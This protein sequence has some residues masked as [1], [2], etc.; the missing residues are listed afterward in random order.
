MFRCLACCL[1]LP[2]SGLALLPSRPLPPV[3]APRDEPVPTSADRDEELR[4]YRV[5]GYGNGQPNGEPSLL[6]VGD[7]GLAGPIRTAYVADFRGIFESR[8]NKATLP[9]PSQLE[10]ADEVLRSLE[11]HLR[12]AGTA[13]TDRRL[14]AI[15]Y[16]LRHLP[17]MDDYSA[18]PLRWKETPL[19]NAFVTRTQGPFHRTELRSI[20]RQVFYDRLTAE[21]RAS[22]RRFF[23]ELARIPR[24]YALYL[25]SITE[26]RVWALASM[27]E[28]LALPESER[29]ELTALAHY[30]RAR[31]R[32]SLPDW[33]ACS[34][35]TVR[36]RLRQVRSDLTS[37]AADLKAGAHD[38]AQVGANAAGWLAYS[39]SMVLPARRLTA[40][41]EADYPGALATYLRLPERRHANGF[42]S[43]H[44]LI[45]KLAEEAA[46]E[47]CVGDLDLRMLMTIHLGGS[48]D[49]VFGFG[50]YHDYGRDA[51]PIGARGWLQ[52]LAAAGISHDFA[53]HRIAM[54][55]LQTGDFAGCERVLRTLNRRDPLTALIASHCNLRQGG[56]K[57]VSLRLLADALLARPP[58]RR[59]RHA[60]IAYLGAGLDLDLTDPQQVANR[61][62]T[63][64]AALKLSEGDLG[65]A[66]R[67]FYAH[68]DISDGAYVAE[69]LLSTDELRRLVDLHG[70]P[71]QD[72]PDHDF[73]LGYDQPHYSPRA[74]LARRLFRE[75]RWDEAALYFPPALAAVA[76][77][78]GELRRLAAQP[79]TQPRARADAHWRAALIIQ[80]HGR[81][82]LF[83]AY[84]LNKTQP[85]GAGKIR[86]NTDPTYLEYANGWHAYLTSFLPHLRQQEKLDEFPQV[87]LRASPEETRRLK[88]WYAQHIE[89]PTYSERMPR[90]EVFRLGLLAVKDLPDNDPAGA[91]ILQT[92]GNLLKYVDPDAAQP[93]YR[94]LVRRFGQT[95]LGA[96]ATKNRWFAKDRPS[97]G[98]DLLR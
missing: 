72:L 58:G 27:D 8:M 25:R 68:G 62:G 29:R 69:C 89:K 91:L 42:N 66:M 87:I 15:R 50:A 82:L 13:D 12:A 33:D 75:D 71:D 17:P 36:Q 3:P 98:E 14:Q 55:H 64:L 2:L 67:L 5:F 59:E 11:T 7:L 92:I 26:P 96:T 56:P 94:L 9:D 74:L 18:R 83:C 45:R 52:A 60:T 57:A 41:G 24:A 39:Y 19:A 53:P 85:A 90:Y 44:W 93:A 77:R 97:P 63:E 65:E 35:A 10:V 78:Y 81:A 70:Y 48:Q 38:F 30:R 32:L 46:F 88:A 73:Y 84:G 49:Y 31:L 76:R 79:D 43:T 95:P 80:R 22:T 21:E 40:L 54:L 6:R 20:Q 1:L 37:I 86:R 34:D 61:V 47:V 28:L 16:H 51:G 23:E 4:Q